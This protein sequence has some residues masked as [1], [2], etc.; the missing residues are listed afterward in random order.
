MNIAEE[1][2]D[3]LATIED[4]IRDE[5]RILNEISHEAN[6]TNILYTGNSG[7]VVRCRQAVSSL[8]K[9][10]G[11]FIND[12]DYSAN[13]TAVNW[14]FRSM[15]I[16]PI[17][18]IANRVVVNIRQSGRLKIQFKGAANYNYTLEVPLKIDVS[19]F[20]SRS[21]KMIISLSFDAPGDGTI[22]PKMVLAPRFI[23]N[24]ELVDIYQSIPVAKQQYFRQ[25]VLNKMNHALVDAANSL[26]P[27]NLGSLTIEPKPILVVYEGYLLRII[28]REKGS[29]R[30]KEPLVQQFTFFRDE[31]VR[32]RKHLVE[33]MIRQR[34]GTLAAVTGVS[35]EFNGAWGYINV[36]TERNDRKIILHIDVK[37]KVQMRHAITFNTD[38]SNVVSL[39]AQN[40]YWKYNIKANRCWPICGKIMRK[41]KKAVMDGINDAQNL[42]QTIGVVS[43]RLSDVLIESDGY[44]LVLGFNRRGNL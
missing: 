18:L 27:I 42:T 14:L 35:W 37:T 11:G 20:N 34:I 31:T 25:V 5:T 44:G 41:A 33:P 6:G 23:E 4:Q 22:V 24:G 39:N 15:R 10:V 13:S 2:F 17:H 9:E 3:S 40:Y 7:P 28:S 38:N 26:E 29:R 19:Q 36:S 8:E 43:Y 12:V 1:I 21:V 32:L 30:N 16:E